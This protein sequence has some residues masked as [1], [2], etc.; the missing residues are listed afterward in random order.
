MSRKQWTVIFLVIAAAICSIAIIAIL[1]LL[2]EMKNFNGEPIIKDDTIRDLL[3]IFLGVFVVIYFLCC[4]GCVW[5]G[6][7]T[8]GIKISHMLFKV[9]EKPRQEMDNVVTRSQ[10]EKSARETAPHSPVIRNGETRSACHCIRLD[11]STRTSPV[12]IPD[13]INELARVHKNAPVPRL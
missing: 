5:Y 4:W 3:L 7:H 11:R 13:I 9:E 10:P 1:R 6:L 8:Y 12:V 2:L